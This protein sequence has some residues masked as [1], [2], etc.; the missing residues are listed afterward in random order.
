MEERILD[1]ILN[2][3]G[4]SDLQITWAS[5]T[6]PE[7]VD[8]HLLILG[9]LHGDSRRDIAPMEDSLSSGAAAGTSAVILKC[10][11]CG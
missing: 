7:Y 1:K 8:T 10:V 3:Y 2:T 5:L 9:H 6:K 4:C 11:R